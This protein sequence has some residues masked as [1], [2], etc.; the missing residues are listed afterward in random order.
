MNT[1]V[2]ATGEPIYLVC[3][4]GFF[5]GNMRLY[6][7][8]PVACLECQRTVAAAFGE[9]ECALEYQAKVR[10]AA[11]LASAPDAALKESLNQAAPDAARC[12]CRPGISIVAGQEHEHKCAIVAPDAARLAEALR[13]IEQKAYAQG[14]SE[15]MH[16]HE[17]AMADPFKAESVA[18]RFCFDIA[19]IA[20]EALAALVSGE[21]TPDG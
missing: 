1:G 9:I 10:A 14:V 19:A 3:G 15:W 13:K 5:Y 16:F 8:A 21:G 4:C 11:A 7:H 18:Q 6:E 12:T 20:R 17:L 2:R